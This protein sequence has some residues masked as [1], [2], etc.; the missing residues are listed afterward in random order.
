MVIARQIRTFID[1]GRA[2]PLAAAAAL[3]LGVG[4]IVGVGLVIDPW[5]AI[6]VGGG[7]ALAI[8]GVL[9]HIERSRESLLHEMRTLWGLSGVVVEGRP[10]PAPGGWALG[11]DA[12]LWT[13]TRIGRDARLSVVE[14]GPGTSSVVLG[15]SLRASSFWGLEHDENFVDVVSRMLAQHG[16][17]NYSLLHAPLSVGED[18]CRWYAEA[19]VAQ[20]PST[21]DLLIVDG[22][23]NLAGS[24][25]RAPAMARLR[26]RLAPGA[27]VLVDD[28]HRKDE[29]AMAHRW[30]AADPTLSVVYDGGSFV[31]LRVAPHGGIAHREG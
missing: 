7:T 11:A 10:W 3:G 22:P 30:C 12:L 17:N 8:S 26:D 23:P 1:P 16:L 21:I 2:R 9:L 29:R 15:R 13:L 18:G 25:N 27:M 6:L 19:A 14:L 31:V 5:G 28:T 24:G 4:V 20:L